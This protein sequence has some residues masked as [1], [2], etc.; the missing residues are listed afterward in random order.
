MELLNKKVAIL[1]LGDENIALINYI[2][3]QG[4]KITICD[5]KNK[6]EI[7]I[8]SDKLSNL[9][10]E[11]RL[12]ENY[13][14]DLRDFNII[15]RTPGLHFLKPQ[16]QEAIKAGIE[17]SSQTKLFFNLCPCKI[18]GITGTK[19]KGTTST[20][21]YEILK[22]D[23]QNKK[24][25]KVY[26]AGNIGRAPID[27]ID[28]LDKNDLVVLELSSFQLQ[29][30][31][32]SPHISVVLDIKV[33]HLDV[34][35]NREEYIE[36]KENIVSHQKKNDFAVINADYE[37][38]LDFASFTSAEVFYFSRKSE[39]KKGVWVKNKESIVLTNGQEEVEL[40]KTN[41]ITLRGEH[42]WEN[43]CGAATAC[44]LAGASIEN[45]N[46]IVKEFHGLEHRL[47]FVKENNGI[48]F[49]NDSFSTTPDTAIAAIN[50]FHEPILLIA[51]GSE[52]GADYEQLG[53][54]IDNSSV[55]TA[56]LIGV[57]GPRIK[58]EIRNSNIEV[59]SDCRNLEEVI[60][61]IGKKAEFGDVVLLSPASASF[62]WF[63]NYKD[64]GK[65]FKEAILQKF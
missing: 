45:I 58:S 32:Q 10:L 24:D 11:Y 44:Y 46:K 13:L 53:K 8:Y 26:L 57:T 35:K 14:E 56:I 48:K 43:I 28:E 52:K 16:I 55:K 29:D 3:K 23:N 25:R 5:S 51:G 62:D 17:V 60:E 34:H 2:S 6:E 18:I 9:Q 47:E 39:L 63:K 65:Q 27:F 64:R 15:F 7:K 12:G 1:G 50:A 37:T 31:D 41:E 19:G 20:L 4:A 36:A 40:V 22:Y 49:Y 30:L 33:D 38:S 54:E 61:T 42:N 59:I 21:I